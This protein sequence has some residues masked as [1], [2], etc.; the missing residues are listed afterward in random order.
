MYFQGGYSIFDAPTTIDHEFNIKLFK[1]VFPE[2]SLSISSCLL[3]LS[4]M[5]G[6]DT[7]SPLLNYDP[8]SVSR[9][10]S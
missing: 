1:H 8:S 3:S 10:M 2:S 5:D 7:G 6:M 9:G 4:L